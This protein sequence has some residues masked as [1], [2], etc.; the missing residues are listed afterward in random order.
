[1]K[2][3]SDLYNKLL[4][5]L[6][7]HSAGFSARKLSALISIIT[8][9]I[10]SYKHSTPDNA[11]SLIITWLAFAATCLGMTTVQLMNKKDELPKL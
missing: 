8:C 7:T 6:D 10:L 11:D 5:S 9:M 4:S 1:M 2:W 3:L